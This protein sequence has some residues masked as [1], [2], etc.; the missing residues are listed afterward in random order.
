M[1]IFG[2]KSKSFKQFVIP[3]QATSRQIKLGNLQQ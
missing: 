1:A 3:A 2:M